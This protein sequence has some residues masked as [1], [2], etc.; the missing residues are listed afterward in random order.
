MDKAVVAPAVKDSILDTIGAT[1][2]VRLSRVG[3][4]LRAQLIAK[5]ESFNPGGSIKDRIAVSLIEAAER[6]GRLRPGGTI[7]EPT[8][9][10]TGTGLAIVARLKGYRVIAVMPD[11]MSREKI[12]LLRAY[13][14][15]VVVAPTDVPPDSPQAYYRVAD[16][17]TEE[18]PGAFQPNQYANPANPQTHYE[19]TGP[20]LWDQLEGRLTHLVVGVGTGGTITGMAHYLRERKPDLVVVGAD[21]EGSI[22]SG[23]EANVRP[24]LI[25]GVGEDFWPQTF[26][27]SVV[28]RW[29]T[30]SDRN[31]FLST[32]RLAQTEGILAGGSGGMALHAALTVAADVDD[33]EAV[34]VVMIPDGG[35]SYL[36]KIYSDA[37]MRQRGFL[38]R[39]AELTVGDVLRRKREAGE[40]PPLVTVEPHFRVRE[41]VALLHEHRVSQLPV[42][43]AHDPSTIVGA[44]GERGLLRRAAADPAL[45]DAEIVEVMEP[46]F[47]G[48]SSQDPVREAVELLVGEQQALLVIHEG[49][50]E[51]LVTRTDL[52]EA[53][54]S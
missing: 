22:Y 38:D 15:E 6:D 47:A 9:G 21:P 27:P 26:D 41:A 14:A 42:V 53:L 7:V 51:G 23:G 54:A 29:V 25:E 30:V 11:K 8:S 49:R 18:I 1:P 19:S 28:D 45:L 2:L 13:G 36:S 12:D 34:I 52:L 44:I 50:A 17:L 31:A 24:Y 43:S 48:V 32:R 20:E 37:W 46:P 5:L 39:G 10:N 33:P 40:I 3:A 35:R 16:R 4:G